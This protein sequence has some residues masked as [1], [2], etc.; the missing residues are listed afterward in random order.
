LEVCEKGE[1]LTF[2]VTFLPLRLDKKKLTL[3]GVGGNYALEFADNT[4]PPRAELCI[5][6]NFSYRLL[7]MVV[8]LLQRERALAVSDEVLQTP[9]EIQ[10]FR[11]SVVS[12]EN[13]Y[14]SERLG[15]SRGG[16]P[17]TIDANNDQ[18]KEFSCAYDT[19]LKHWSKADALYEDDAQG[20]LRFANKVGVAPWLLKDFASRRP[21]KCKPNRLAHFDAAIRSEID[22]RHK[23]G[24]R[25][26]VSLSTLEKVR[27]SGD[28][29]RGISRKRPKAEIKSGACNRK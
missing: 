5:P 13:T 17:R 15:V 21:D 14:I 22:I 12:Y 23:T 29:L 18:R 9:A 2:T 19:A 26:L 16:S 4:L 24:K 1:T 3:I 6:P 10:R 7:R 8:H 11:K 28:L 25:E 20:A 27:K